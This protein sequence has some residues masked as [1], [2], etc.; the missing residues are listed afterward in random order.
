MEHPD[1]TNAVTTTLPVVAKV[2]PQRSVIIRFEM[3]TPYWPLSMSHG[4]PLYLAAA[5]E[6]KRLFATLDHWVG[7]NMLADPRLRELIFNCPNGYVASKTLKAL[8]SHNPNQN[9]ATIPR[10]IKVGD[11]GLEGP[12]QII[13]DWEIIRDSIMR[14]GIE[15]KFVGHRSIRDILL[16]TRSLEI[17]DCSRRDPY[18]CNMIEPSDRG[19]PG[20]NRHAKLLMEYRDALIV[21]QMERIRGR[22]R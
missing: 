18:W 4:G 21:H 16:D 5:G 13:E 10:F 3:S 20:M 22:K 19:I 11:L 8:L 1:F 9:D 17:Y 2:K 12:A 6:Q 7:Y 14:R 15:A